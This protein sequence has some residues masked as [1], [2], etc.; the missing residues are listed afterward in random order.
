MMS[1]SAWLTRV[2]VL[3]ASTIYVVLICAI[4][5]HTVTGVTDDAVIEAKEKNGEAVAQ[6]N[7]LRGTILTNL[8]HLHGVAMIIASDRGVQDLAR[9][10]DTDP[11]AIS[12]RLEEFSKKLSVGVIWV[13]NADG[14]CVSSSNHGMPESFVGVMY[15]DRDYFKQAKAGQSG[16]QFA[17]GRKSNIPGLYFSAPI[18]VDGVFTGAVI[19]KIDLPSVNWI[20]QFDAFIHDD[21]GVVVLARNKRFEGMATPGADISSVPTKLA[22]SIYKRTTFDH[23]HL[24]KA[25]EVKGLKMGNL[26]ELDR[27]GN[28]VAMAT[29][30]IP[31]YKMTINVYR[32]MPVTSHYDEVIWSEFLRNALVATLLY[33]IAAISVAYMAAKIENHRTLSDMAYFDP[34]TKL[35][36]RRLLTDRLG[37]AVKNAKRRRMVGDKPY[38][39]LM[40]LDLDNFKLVNDTCGHDGGDKVLVGVAERLKRCVRAVDTVARLAGDE[41]VVLVEKIGD[42]EEQAISNAVL[43]AEKIMAELNRPH[44]VPCGGIERGY[45][46]SPSIGIHVFN[47]EDTVLN[48]MK[49]AD[50]AMY[51]TKRA[52][53]NG[54]GIK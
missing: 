5:Y 34:L 47:D 1:G 26:F 36:N 17:V 27:A 25:K 23:L 28:V 42:T 4:W 39:A 7:N 30:A 12:K 15:A 31:A 52:G 3:V 11:L 48:A 20:D 14:L 8:R 33:A 46:C 2:K 16:Y 24:T 6:A 50:Q 21:H 51:D 53:K 40:F 44:M 13:L 22:Q 43:V 49:M 9:H 41:F 37:Q 29:E 54:Y 18:L 19:V 45:I 35:C 38:G 10:I 32:D